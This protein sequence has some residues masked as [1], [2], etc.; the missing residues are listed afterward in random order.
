M[1]IFLHI[2]RDSYVCF[3]IAMCAC[4]HVFAQKNAASNTPNTQKVLPKTFALSSA[5]GW[6]VEKMNQ[7]LQSIPLY[8]WCKIFG[9]LCRNRAFLPNAGVIGDSEKTSGDSGSSGEVAFEQK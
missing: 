8:L 4:A 6:E 1:C 7:I 3:K 5:E 9:E 2:D